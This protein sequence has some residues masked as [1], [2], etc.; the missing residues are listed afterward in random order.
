MGKTAIILG[1]TGLTGSMLLAQLI[2]D[3]RYKKIILFS[4]KELKNMPTKVTQHVGSLLELENFKKDFIGD[5]VF[6]CIGT[7]SKKT[8]DKKLYKAIDYG[9][10]VT[11]SKLAKE[12]RIN[13]FLVISALGANANSCIFYNKTKGKMEQD[14]LK[15]NIPN[16]YILQPSII[17]GNRKENRNAEKLGLGVFKLFQ[18][19]LIGKLKKYRLIEAEDIAKAMLNLANS[20]AINEIIITSDYIKKN[21][22]NNN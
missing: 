3:K 20:K 15:Q 6:C 19:L 5:E 1:A 2:K 14:V 7:T 9:I 10:P 22:K 4:R 16:T 18:P 21:S 13:T 12:N 11:A 17:A 8:P